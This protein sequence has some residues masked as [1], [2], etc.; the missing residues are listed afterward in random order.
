MSCDIIVLIIIALCF[1]VFTLTLSVLTG[2]SLIAP[3]E[4][5]K[6]VIK[7]RLVIPGLKK[8]WNWISDSDM[9]LAWF[10]VLLWRLDIASKEISLSSY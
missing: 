7:S 10:I 4:E 3:N 6:K 2:L 1:F 5:T 9:R 8:A